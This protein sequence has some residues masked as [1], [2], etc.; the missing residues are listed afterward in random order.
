M[1]KHIDNNK[2]LDTFE[3]DIVD[4]V[5]SNTETTGLMPALAENDYK[6]DSYMEIQKFQQR[7]VTRKEQ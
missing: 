6:M 3:I 7:P 2:A 5:V 1:K 4:D